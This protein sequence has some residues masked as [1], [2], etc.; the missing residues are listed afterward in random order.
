M[1]KNEDLGFS[2][3]VSLAL[4]RIEKAKRLFPEKRRGICFRV[5]S[6]DKVGRNGSA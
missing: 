3:T 6:V 4:R 2:P 5:D 1:W